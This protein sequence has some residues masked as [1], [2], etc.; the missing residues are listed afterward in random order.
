MKQTIHEKMQED[1]LLYKKLSEVIKDAIAEHRAKRLS[2][3]EYLKKIR[4]TM[5]EMRSSG[6][7]DLPEPLKHNESAKPYYRVVTVELPNEMVMEKTPSDVSAEVAVKI[8]EIIDEHKKRDWIKDSSVHNKM[9]NAIEDYLFQM[10][11]RYDLTWDYD[12]IDRIIEES[13][14]IAKSREL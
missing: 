1:P 9:F 13:L 14:E 12:A 3:A 7:S 5:D 8:N 11:G 4:E 2:D 6:S 10:K